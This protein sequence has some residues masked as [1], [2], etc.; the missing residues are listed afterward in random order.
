MQDEELYVAQATAQNAARSGI[1]PDELDDAAPP[2]HR[3]AAHAD[4]RAPAARRGAETD[5]SARGTAA[6]DGLEQA[7]D[8]GSRPCH[9]GDPVPAEVTAAIETEL[10]RLQD[11]QRRLMR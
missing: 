4:R 2:G 9:P 1:G 3:G 11:A 7:A 8:D 5:R 10:A 6:L